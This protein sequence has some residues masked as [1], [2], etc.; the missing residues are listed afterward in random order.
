MKLS[1]S[2]GQLGAL[3]RA[4]EE[5]RLLAD[6][7]DDDRL[8]AFDDVADDP[9]ADAVAN[10][11]GRRVEA[12]AGLD[13]QLAVLVEQRDHA[14]DGPVMLREDLEHAVQRRPKIE[15]ARERLADFE[16]RGEP[17]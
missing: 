10:R 15:R 16:Q 2:F 11:V 3:R 12:V 6:A 7:R 13:V 14:P 5:R 4:V 17:P 9:L 1:S 8:A